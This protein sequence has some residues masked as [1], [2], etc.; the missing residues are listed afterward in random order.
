MMKTNNEVPRQTLVH[1]EVKSVTDR[2]SEIDNF[3]KKNQKKY[4]F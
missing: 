4:E 2:P 1:R 3:L